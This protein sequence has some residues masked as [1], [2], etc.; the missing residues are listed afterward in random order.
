M[1]GSPTSSAAPERPRCADSS[2]PARAA[3]SATRP[4]PRDGWAG[5]G[6]A[7]GRRRRAYV[8]GGGGQRAQES[9]VLAQDRLLQRLQLGAGVEP[10]LVGEQPAHPPQRRQ[11]VGLPAG[12]GQGDG[13]Q[14]PPALLERVGRHGRLRHRQQSRVLAEGQ[15]S[16]HPRLLGRQPQLVQRRTLGVDV[17]VVAEVGVRSPGPRPERGLERLDLGRDVGPVRP[18]VGVTRA[19]LGGERRERVDARRTAAAKACTSTSAGSTRSTYPWS[20]VSSTPGAST[21]RSREM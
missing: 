21:R 19:Q 7:T 16:E 10:E 4:T 14:A 13:V 18:A 1:P 8:V 15:Q 2:S 5:D 12:A 11:R 9:G 20:V 3:R 17:G 6:P